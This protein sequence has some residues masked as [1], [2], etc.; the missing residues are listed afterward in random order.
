VNIPVELRDSMSRTVA[1]ALDF[2]LDTLDYSPDE[3]I[4]PRT[5][6]E[7]KAQ[8][9]ADPSP[10]DMFAVVVWNDE[11]HSFEDVAQIIGD[12]VG[13]ARPKALKCA[14]VIDEQ[15]CGFVNFFDLF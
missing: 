14:D 6:E 1:Y 10:V 4:T 3:A 9:T 15:E 12:T 2:I 5:E 11:K 13:M 8:P 7:L